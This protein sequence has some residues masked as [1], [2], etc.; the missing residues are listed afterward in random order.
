MCNIYKTYTI[1]V[2]VQ[3]TGSFMLDTGD[4]QHV[5]VAVDGPWSEQ[6]QLI[7]DFQI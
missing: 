1:Y 4:T 7:F 5:A 2:S 6:S 3:G